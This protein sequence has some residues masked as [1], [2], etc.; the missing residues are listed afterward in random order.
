MMFKSR[1]I[2]AMHKPLHANLY[3]IK[4][5]CLTFFIQLL[6]FFTMCGVMF[7]PFLGLL[8]NLHINYTHIVQLCQ[9]VFMQIVQ[10]GE[11]LK[12]AREELKKSAVAFADTFDIPYRTYIS[13]ERNERS[14]PHD[15]LAQIVQK[16]NLNLDFLYYGIGNIFKQDCIQETTYELPVRGDVEA[17]MG[18]GVTVYNESITSTYS[19]S[20]KFADD[21]G[22]NPKTSEVI[23]ARGDS[24]ETTI[25][26]GDS[27]ILDLSKR[28]IHDGVIY[29]IKLDGEPLI[30]R[31]QRLS[32]DRIGVVSD[33][34]KYKMR[35][36]I[37]NEN[38]IDGF[39]VIGEVRWW[40][41]IAK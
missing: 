39:E 29:C 14:I 7:M 12:Q 32:P 28:N 38:N 30:K 4:A 31:L 24:M 11:N 20:R 35:E 6:R 21:L 15:K 36:V 41:R 3:L 1:A 18:Y 9:E 33:N 40:G 13:Y 17:S 2:S 26:G 19:I 16:Y 22:I 27:V 25:F 23:F 34:P 5:A 37:L 8:E 10:I